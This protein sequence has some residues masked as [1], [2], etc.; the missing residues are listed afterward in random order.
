MAY[1]LEFTTLLS[2]PA[3]DSSEVV[4]IS[5]SVDL[6]MFV[7]MTKNFTVTIH[8]IQSGQCLNWIKLSAERRYL[9][10][11][12]LSKNGYFVVASCAKETARTINKNGGYETYRKLIST[13]QTFGI[14]GE[15]ITAEPFT[16]MNDIRGMVIKE[17][18]SALAQTSVIEPD[19]NQ[20]QSKRI[21]ERLMN[22]KIFFFDENNGYIMN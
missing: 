13:L 20:D 7:S 10:G 22:D 18:S 1:Y 11:V 5:S 4:S 6:G 17:R 15:A 16:C 8:S 3:T 2:S 21:F 9:Q 19:S 14:N 12:Q